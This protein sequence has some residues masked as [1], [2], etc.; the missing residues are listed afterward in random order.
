VT[1]E[2]RRELARLI[3]RA[4][5]L[6]QDVIRLE[7]RDRPGSRATDEEQQAYRVRQADAQTAQE[8]RS[9]LQTLEASLPNVTSRAEADRMIQQVNETHGYLQVLFNRSNA[10]LR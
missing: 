1:S 9:Y 3:D 8:Y 10:T 7:R 5:D 4:D 2:Q 6:A